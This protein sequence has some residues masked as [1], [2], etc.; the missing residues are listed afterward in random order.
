MQLIL[1]TGGPSQDWPKAKSWHL[2]AA[3]LVTW[4]ILLIVSGE[5]S[6]AYNIGSPEGGPLTYGAYLCSEMS[7]V[8]TRIRD[9][10]VGERS[11]YVPE[12]S[13]S[14]STISEN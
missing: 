7:G 5:A 11:L 1:S 3:D 8:G 2:D 12:V 14:I 9:A 13:K 4:L 10:P 6:S